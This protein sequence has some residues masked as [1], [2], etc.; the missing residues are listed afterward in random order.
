VAD[1][2][3]AF[4]VVSIVALLQVAIFAS[5]DVLGGTPD[6][7]LVTLIGLALLRGP[8]FGAVAGFWAGILLDVAN[9][10]TLGVT[11]LLLTMA[12]YWTGRYGDTTARE[13]GHA[14]Y[15]SV[16]VISILYAL[17]SLIL[18]YVLGRPT[19]AQLVL[20][21]S[22]FPSVGLNLLVTLPVY[23]ICRRVFRPD[24]PRGQRAQEMQLLG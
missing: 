5:V 21:D 8:M 22:L 4:V 7:V 12:G 10:D 9:L 11:S 13:R 17:G 3:K 23:A 15:L 16:A 20:V 2:A 24:S 19:S 6:L 18:H 14:P 1:A